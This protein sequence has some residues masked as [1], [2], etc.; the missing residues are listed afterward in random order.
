ME[1]LEYVLATPWARVVA[2]VLLWP[3]VLVL[4]AILLIVVD[5]MR[6]TWSWVF[7]DASL[8]SEWRRRWTI[9]TS[10]PWRFLAN[11]SVFMVALLAVMAATSSLEPRWLRVAAPGTFWVVLSVAAA[12]VNARRRRLRA[13]G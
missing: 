5:A 4:C 13:C 9:T 8:A 7:D 2:S 6:L 3:A 10:Q 12:L 11:N 1:A